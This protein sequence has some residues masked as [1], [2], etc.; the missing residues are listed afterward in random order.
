MLEFFNIIARGYPIIL[1][2]IVLGHFI[3]T[4]NPESLYLLVWLFFV[5]QLNKVLKLGLKHIFGKKEIPILGKGERPQEAKDCGCIAN[6][7]KPTSYGMPSGH[8]HTAAFFSVYSI[9]VINSHPI[10]EGIKTSLAI[11]LTA[12]AFWIMYSRTIFKCHTVQQVLMG[13]ILGSIF[14]V[15]AFNLK[16]IVLQK[17]K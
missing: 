16:N 2:I 5:E 17:I 7:K 15:I 12:L 14:G 6:N 11:I 1:I 10:S 13:G 4:K 8:S 9:L 3:G